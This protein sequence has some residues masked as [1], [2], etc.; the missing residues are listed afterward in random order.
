MQNRNQS[1]THQKTIASDRALAGDDSTHHFNSPRSFMVRTSCSCFQNCARRA[2]CWRV[3]FTWRRAWPGYR[4]LHQQLATTRVGA[5]GPSATKRTSM[6]RLLRRLRGL[7]TP[8]RRLRVLPPSLRELRLLRRVL[9]T[10]PLL[11]ATV[12]R[13]CTTPLLPPLALPIWRTTTRTLMRQHRYKR[14]FAPFPPGCRD[15]RGALQ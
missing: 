10:S 13:W 4:S 8:P 14:L 11:V 7:A 15:A 1:R 9:P 2:A 3:T 6:E 12:D 5:T